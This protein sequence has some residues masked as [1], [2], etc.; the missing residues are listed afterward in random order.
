MAW[1]DYYNH[2]SR[3]RNHLRDRFFSPPPQLPDGIQNDVLPAPFRPTGG[4]RTRQS[5]RWS[6]F[7]IPKFRIGAAAHTNV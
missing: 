5:L 4:S 6:F 1:M 7:F 3:S 2:S